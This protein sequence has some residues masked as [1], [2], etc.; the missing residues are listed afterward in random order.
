M[1]LRVFFLIALLSH[2]MSCAWRVSQRMDGSTAFSSS[3]WWREYI[4]DTYWLQMTMTT[5]GYGDIYPQGTH[6]RIFAILAMLI[7]PIFFGSVV[8]VLSHITKGILNDEVEKQV[9][10]AMRFMRRRGVPA[11]LQRRVDHNL[12]RVGPRPHHRARAERRGG[13][14]GGG[15]GPDHAAARRARRPPA[16]RGPQPPPPHQAGEQDHEQHEPARQAL[17]RGAAR[18]LPRAPEQDNGLVP[19]LPGR[20]ASLRRRMLTFP[21]FQDAP[22]A[23]IADIAHAHVWV[24]TL[25]GDL[26]VE[27]GQLVQELVFV[28]HGLLVVQPGDGGGGQPPGRTP[29]T[30]GD[31]LEYEAGAWFGEE[32]LFQQN[33]IRKFNSCAAVES[34]LAVLAVQEFHRVL[35]QY[36]PQSVRHKAI[37]HA[38]QSKRLNVTEIG[39]RPPT[40]AHA[41]SRKSWVNFFQR[42]L[43]TDQ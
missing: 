34:E 7:A 37:E 24:Q 43:D 17:A 25:P 31:Q 30:G 6:S 23:F 13:D 16:A 18:A 39:Y 38:I 29:D 10:E 21:L 8:S 41:P 5:V 15:G 11:D 22:H 2:I 35:Q 33:C 20:A 14:A 28:I 9:G 36:P 4:A 12:R 26:V 27:E 42:A 32:C 19:P 40:Q 3:E 1:F